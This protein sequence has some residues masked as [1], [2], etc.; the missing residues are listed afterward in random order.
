MVAGL[1]YYLALKRAP[2]R[3]QMLKSMYEEEFQRAADE[4]EDRVPLKLQPSVSYLR[5]N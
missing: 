1:A 2:E 5:V 3:V 4:D